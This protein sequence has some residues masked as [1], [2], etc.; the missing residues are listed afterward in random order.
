[1][2]KADFP[3]VRRGILHGGMSAMIIDET[4]GALVY[5]LKRD[6]VIGAGPAF[7]AHL[8]ASYQYI[9]SYRARR[10]LADM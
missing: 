3:G 10:S 2:S 7:T 5:V 4:L 6:G 9:S 8:G 1:M